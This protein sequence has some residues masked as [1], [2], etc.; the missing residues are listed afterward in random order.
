[1]QR[2][3]HCFEPL[4]RLSEEPRHNYVSDFK[5][6]KKYFLLHSVG[7]KSELQLQTFFSK[8]PIVATQF[9][10]SRKYPSSLTFK[11]PLFPK[12]FSSNYERNSIDVVCSRNQLKYEVVSVLKN[13]FNIS[14]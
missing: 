10:A 13:I 14:L 9:T 3:S 4:L 1:M 6:F 5:C 7:F 2:Y 11:Q 12:Y 8:L